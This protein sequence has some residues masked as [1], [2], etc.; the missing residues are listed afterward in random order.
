MIEQPA[1]A[2]VTDAPVSVSMRTYECCGGISFCVCVG[3]TTSAAVDCFAVSSLG[4]ARGLDDAQ[5]EKPLDA[6]IPTRKYSPAADWLC[7]PCSAGMQHR[8]FRLQ[9]PSGREMPSGAQDSGRRTAIDSCGGLIRFFMA[10]RG[11]ACFHCSRSLFPSSIS[12]RQPV[13]RRQPR[14]RATNIRRSSAEAPSHQSVHDPH[15]RCLLRM[16]LREIWDGM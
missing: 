12:R 13:E 5:S 16:L 10:C 8:N 7:C 15:S 14:A 2:D 1:N 3:S 6:E 9:K 11:A 4:L